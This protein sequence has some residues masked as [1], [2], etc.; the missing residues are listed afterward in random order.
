M[1][2]NHQLDYKDP[3]KTTSIQWKVRGREF[4]WDKRVKRIVE[5]SARISNLGALDQNPGGLRCV[6][7]VI[8]PSFYGEYNK[9]L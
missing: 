5:K 2:W 3:Y 4:W 1:G 7:G 6:E 9:P 8:L